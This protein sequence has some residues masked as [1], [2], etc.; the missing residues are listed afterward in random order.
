M[1]TQNEI[2]D[3]IAARIGALEFMVRQ[4]LSAHIRSSDE[5]PAEAIAMLQATTATALRSKQDSLS[6]EDE[7]RRFAQQSVHIARIYED[8][9]RALEEPGSYE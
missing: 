9:L 7:K 4:L 3:D 5:N 2:F 6:H 8:L 1:A